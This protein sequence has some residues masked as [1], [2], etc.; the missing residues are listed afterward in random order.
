[1]E[2][3]A[4]ASADPPRRSPWRHPSN[5]GNPN[6]NGDAVIDTTSWPALSEAA[7]NP[8]KP[9]PCIDS[10]SEGLGKQSSR[11][12]PARRGGAGADH[13]PSPRDDRAT[14]WDHGR[15]HHHHNSGGRRGSFGGR[16]RGGGGGGF[17]ALYRAPIGPYVRGAT[18]PPPPPPPPMAVA[19]PPFLPPPL[20][21]FAAPLLF[22]HDMASPV[23]PVSPIYYV[24]PPPP[25]EA[26][27]PLPPF[28]PTML[29]PPAYPYYHPQPQPDP[30]PEPDADPQQHRANLLK[31]IEFYFSKDNLCTDVFLR[32]NMDDQGWVNIALIAGFNKVQ[33]STDDLQYIKDTIQSSSILEMQ[34][35]KI[36]RQNDWN[37]WVIPRESNTD[38]LP[39][40]NINNLT[41][42]LGSVGLQESAASSSSMV[43]ENH[44]EILTNGPTSGNNQAPVVEDGAGKL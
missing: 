26:L 14:S 33:E 29:A 38:V 2:P 32:R 28:P 9:P 36:R 3:S 31:Q 22:H 8:P 42:H 10:P 13:S 12:K 35:D 27:R 16:R 6:P 17:D 24:G 41:A 37:K 4:S 43:D 21:P 11:H 23:S 15:H 34:D 20:R 40:P 44:H 18:A 7:R 19:P 1:M 5:G 39:S 25:P 30:E